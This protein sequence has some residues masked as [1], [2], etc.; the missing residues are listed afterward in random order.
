MTG[1]NAAALAAE[2]GLRLAGDLKPAVRPSPPALEPSR[3]ILPVTSDISPLLPYGGLSTMT[4]ITASRLGATSLLWRLLAGPT[5]AGAWCALAGLPRAYPPAATAAGVDLDRLALVDAAGPRIVDA[6][7]ALAG[8]VAVL[9]VPTGVF[10]PKQ[11]RRLAARAR[12]HGTSIVWWET[13]PVVGSDARLHV[14]QAHWH[15]LRS[16]EGRRCGAGR[17][18]SCELDVSARWRTGGVHRARIWPYGGQLPD[19]VVEMRGR[20]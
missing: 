10:A 11:V 19:N 17:L 4:T 8:G 9:V 3:H 6:A 12:R 14:A 16:N 20:P 1:V 18:D 15:G 7:G 2:L 5:R 13:R